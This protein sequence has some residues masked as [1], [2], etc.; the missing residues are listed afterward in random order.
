MKL[1]TNYQEKFQ[2][3]HIAPNAADTAQMLKTIGAGS[4]DELIAQ[5]IP[6][7]IRLK[8]PLNLPP[9]K[10]EFDYLNTLRQAASKN[11]VFKSFIGRGYYDVIV[12]G[13]IQRNILENPGWYTQYTPYQAEIAQGRLQALLNFQTMVIDLTGMEIA[14]ASLLDEGTAAA[15][16]MFMQYSLRKNQDAKIF[17]VSDEVFP[18][19]IDILKT[20]SEPYGIQIQIGDHRKVELNENIFGAIVQYPAGHGAVYDYSDF[21]AKAHEKG[22]KLTVVADIMS[23]AL[24]TPPGEWGAD[25]VVGSTQRFGVPM[26]FGGPHAAFFA[27][28]EEY[29]RSI[30]GRII[31][32]TIDSAG[33]Y[34]LRMALQTREQHIRRDKATSNICTAQALLAIMAGCY[35]VYHGP[36][37]I[38]LIAER[39]HGLSI[40]LSQSLEQLG[41]KQLNESYFDTLKFDLGELV[42][43]IHAEAINHEMNLN[44]EG[45]VV[46]ISIDETTSSE[47]IK[48]MVRFF[49]KVKGKTLSDVSFDELKANIE[50]VIPAALQRKSEF[51]THAI[52][53]THHSEHEMLR[54]I[55]SL[56]AKDLSLCHSMIALGSCTMKLN[57]TTEMV[58]VTWPEFSKMH[59][60]APADQ[61]GGYM[62]VFD[63]LNNWLSEITGFAAMSLQPNAGAQGEYA[64]LM[65]IRAYHHDRGEGH[66]NIALIP[67]SAH[68]TNPAS[69]AMAGMKIV[70]V[71]CDENGN[72]DVNDLRE[73]AVQHKDD[74]SCLMVTYPSTHGVFEEGIIEMCEIIHQNGGQVYMDGANMNAQVGLTSPANIGA[75]VCHLNLH[76]TFCIP[77]G[78]GG[79]GMGPIGVAKHLVPYLPGHAVVDIDRGKSIHAVSAAPWGS[80]SILIISHAYIAMMG[81]DGLTNATR[82]AI[83]NAN[84]IKS[85]LKH[86]Y[87][88]LY[89][90]ANGR[91]AHEMI[92][93]CRS[94]KGAGIEVIDIAKRLMDYG[95]HA[96]TVSFP[97]AGTVMI[98]PTESEPKH[99]LDRF[100]DA[101][102]AI[103]HEIDD[104][105]KGLFDKVN[106]PLKNAPHTAAVVTGNDWEHSYSR[107]KAAFPLPYVADYKFW[108]SVGRVNDTYGDRTLI[109]SCPPLEHYEFEES[110]IE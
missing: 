55:K 29:K 72:I 109:C 88:V 33:N 94:F 1:N 58:P 77:H 87:P 57:A 103:R 84:Y 8:K 10:S 91:C 52:F 106:N 81:A 97:V 42:G 68:G 74:L 71:K 56:E 53:N 34:A 108:P 39:I 75:D 31:G 65:V 6:S 98:E 18:Q 26:G 51:L 90:G 49:A 43:P 63:E 40:L 95:F 16:A 104:I 44:Y 5:T 20:R 110:V 14:N 38:K 25:V 24:L 13:V 12:P 76:K 28:K 9:A 2:Y 30:P 41:Y 107:Q 47:D 100:C 89:T 80:A 19:T 15:E 27:T 50:T 86:H 23:L 60:F 99:E 37:G 54:Y 22:I 36:E 67:S 82:Y 17:F 48:T 45:S 66:R 11:K 83:L 101:M 7:N 78:G 3:R 105:E 62:Q 21:A 85:R 92:L 93:D 64:G 46:T 32:V 4:L 79:P 61:V 70:V 35:A 59:P 69:A 96:P 73:K 102:I